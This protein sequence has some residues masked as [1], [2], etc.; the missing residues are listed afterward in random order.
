MSALPRTTN[1]DSTVSGVGWALLPVE[2]C[3]GQECPSYR[4]LLSQMLLLSWHEL[5][6]K[7]FGFVQ[8]ESQLDGFASKRR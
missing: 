6:G 3:D 1:I 8:V 4:L 7:Q 2:D 5:E